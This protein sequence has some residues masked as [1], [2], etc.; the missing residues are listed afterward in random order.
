MKVE[1]VPLAHSFNCC[2]TNTHTTFQVMLKNILTC[3]SYLL[4]LEQHEARSNVSVAPLIRQ[5]KK[6]TLRTN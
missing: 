4:P 3:Q 5:I 1:T 2:I 6:T